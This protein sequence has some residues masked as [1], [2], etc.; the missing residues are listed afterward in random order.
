MVN[1]RIA[2]VILASTLAGGTA[3]ADSKAWTAIK[4]KLPAG[5][6]VVG[7]IDVAAIHATPSFPKLMAWITS[8]DKDVAQALELVKATCAIDLPAAFSDVAFALDA[9][10]KGVLA[11]GLAGLDQAKVADCA[12]KVISQ[13]EPSVKLAVKPS[14]KLLQY[15]IGKDSVFAAWPA[16]DVV[17]IS[18]DPSNHV[19]LDAMLAGAA[20]A[21]DLATFVGKAPA[22]AAVWAAFA[23]TEDG[24]KGGYASLALGATLK[25]AAVVTAATPKDAAKG[26]SEAKTAIK[27]G[28]SRSAKQPDLKKVFSAVKVGGAGADVTLGLAVPEALLPSLF[29]AF[30]KVF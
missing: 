26:R 8:E 23:I 24:V 2:L 11:F 28:L 10:G 25:V 17:V 18:V 16:K 6:A 27:E 22:S 1:I 20:P 4:G 3:A 5:T 13:A 12:G 15:A 19:G 29:P 30:D 9:D 7:S 21:G 14:G